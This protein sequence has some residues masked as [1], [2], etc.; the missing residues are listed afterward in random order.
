MSEEQQP[1]CKVV[2]SLAKIITAENIQ[3][4]ILGYKKNG[5]PRAAYDIIKDYLEPKKKKSSGQKKKKDSYAL[6]LKAK[7]K[8]KKK[9]DSWIF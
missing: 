9:K 8:K 7:K 6:Y 3:K 4:Y 1:S 5:T 2:N